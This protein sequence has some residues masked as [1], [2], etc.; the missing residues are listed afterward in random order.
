MMTSY[1]SKEAACKKQAGETHRRAAGLPFGERPVQS[2]R[3]R[4]RRVPK[5]ATSVILPAEPVQ[6]LQQQLHHL[7]LNSIKNGYRPEACF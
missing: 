3:M 7:L 6:Y 1:R 2:S 4:A 5:P